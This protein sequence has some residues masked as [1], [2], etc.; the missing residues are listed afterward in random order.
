MIIPYL[1][2]PGFN[3]GHFLGNTQW[4]IC[5]DSTGF[6]KPILRGHQILAKPCPD[7]RVKTNLPETWGSDASQPRSPNIGDMLTTCPTVATQAVVSAS[8]PWCRLS[9]SKFSFN[10]YGHFSPNLTTWCSESL[11]RGCRLTRCS[12]RTVQEEKP[13][14][15]SF[16]M[17]W[18][19]YKIAGL[20]KSKSHAENLVRTR[21]YFPISKL[22]ALAL[23]GCRNRIRLT[24]ETLP[25]LARR[26][27][28]RLPA[29]TTFTAFSNVIGDLACLAAIRAG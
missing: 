18:K 20:T 8:W 15:I 7:L 9:S 1:P 3:S 5:I 29:H 23:L 6:L 16:P 25:E 26:F 21:T 28:W 12:A 17:E 10:Q 24:V 22:L 11:K 2:N 13:Y 4:I 14:H 27:N 19:L